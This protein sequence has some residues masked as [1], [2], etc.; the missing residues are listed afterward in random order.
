MKLLSLVVFFALSVFFPA[1]AGIRPSFMLDNSTW[2]ATHIVVATEGDE[3]D[4]KLTVIESWKGDL[5]AGEIVD[6]PDLAAFKTDASREV[7]Y[8]LG[9]GNESRIKHVTGKRMVLFLIKNPNEEKAAGQEKLP[10]TPK[11]WL[12]ANL[13]KEVNT[14]ILWIEGEKSFA[15][16]QIINPGPSE[17]VE[18]SASET[19][20]KAAVLKI[21]KDQ[22]ELNAINVIE[23]KLKRAEMLKRFTNSENYFARQFAF[24]SFGVCGPEALPILREMLKEESNMQLHQHVIKAMTAAAPDRIG[25]ELVTILKDETAFWKITGPNLKPGWWND[26]S[27]GDEKRKRLQDRYGKVLEILYSLRKLKYVPCKSA[28]A[29][30]RD[31]WR[32][33]PQL[34]DRSGLNQMSEACDHVLRELP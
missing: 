22:N 6:V 5:R 31:F 18:Y 3:I 23:D 33:L 4:G 27:V 25:E 16:M 8:F 32:S 29:E 21:I 26:F 7:H 24:A 10:V 1:V 2:H 28:V 15:F 19:T 34:E 17:L 9:E 14:A 12:P 13:Y 20:I 11:R 30:F